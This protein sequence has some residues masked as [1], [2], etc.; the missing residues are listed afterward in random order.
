[1]VRAQHTHTRTPDKNSVRETTRAN[2]NATL[3]HTHT[4]TRITHIHIHT[5]YIKCM[6]INARIRKGKLENTTHAR[7]KINTHTKTH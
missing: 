1:M 3:T 5:Y 2:T 6:Y 7:T 4:H